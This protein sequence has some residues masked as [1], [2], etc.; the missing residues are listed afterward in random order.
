MV[1]ALNYWD[2]AQKRNIAIDI[3]GLKEKLGIPIVPISASRAEGITELKDA[4][5]Q[6]LDE[7]PKLTSPTRPEPIEEAIS[8]VRSEL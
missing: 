1:L 8:G 5:I 2:T 6:A 3:E 4:A 7:K